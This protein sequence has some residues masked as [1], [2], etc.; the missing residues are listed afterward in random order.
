MFSARTIRNVGI[1]VSLAMFAVSLIGMTLLDERGGEFM[2][3]LAYLLCGQGYLAWYANPL[4]L[5]SI[6]LL[7]EGK[8]RWASVTAGIATALAATTFGIQETILN[9]AGHTAPVVGYGWGFYL[10]MG[11]CLSLLATCA[12]CAIAKKSVTNTAPLT[13][14]QNMI[15]NGT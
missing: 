8:S 11:S 7:R 10:W 4:L 6:L 12:A 5:F 13:L 14:A 1:T 3:G 15:P 2:V 9:E